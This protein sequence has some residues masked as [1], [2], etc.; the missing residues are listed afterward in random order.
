MLLSFLKTIGRPLF[1]LLFS[2]EYHGLE[3]VPENGSVIIAGNH[4][5]YLDP[6]LVMLPVRRPVRFMAWDALFNIPLFGRLIRALGAFPVDLRK[7]KGEAAYRQAVRVLESGDILGIFPEGGR[8]EWGVMGELRNGV[9]R[10][11]IETGAPI[12]PV[13]IGGAFRAW[14]KWKL[15]PKPAKIVV[16]FHRPIYLE[17]EDRRSRGD[18]RDFHQQVM[19]LVAVE[20]NRSLIPTLRGAETLERWYRRPP[21][22]IRTFEWAP[23]I[24]M[25]VAFWVSNERGTLKTHFSGILIP[26]LYY[27]YL[28]CDLAVIKPSRLAKWLRNSAPV[29]L[30]VVWHY[31][32]TEALVVPSGERNYWL[33]GA[34][35][36]AFFPFFYEDY[37][38]LQKFVRGLVTT[39]YL[40]LALQLFRP[41]PLGIMVSTL[42][43]IAIFVFWYG[44]IYKWLIAITM[45]VVINLALFFGNAQDAWLLVYA[46][47]GLVVNAYLQ[48]FISIAYDIRRA[49]NVVLEREITKE[50]NA[51]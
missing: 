41:Q 51:F 10:L 7:G 17:D 47:L 31:P 34:V 26:V 22:H 4:P 19:Q 49:G 50:T 15:L 14:P 38:S 21:S 33:V 36:A 37:Y 12:V 16:R 35:L 43:F 44:V 6:A 3:N 42:M 39:Y 32:L 18:D 11:A 25:I 1:R 24:A 13:T 20:I 27:L 30:M 9:A 23:L 5:S 48:T 40:S 8:S 45:S 46:L 28:I 2:A 29:W